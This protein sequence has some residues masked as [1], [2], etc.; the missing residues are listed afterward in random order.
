MQASIQSSDPGLLGRCELCCNGFEQKSA[1]GLRQSM[2]ASSKAFLPIDDRIE[3]A[4]QLVLRSRVF[5]DIWF[6]FESNDTRPA[7]LNTM[8]E[9][10]EFFRFAPHAHL[11]AFVVTI[12]ALFDKR[13]DTLSLLNLVTEMTSANLLSSLSQSEVGALVDEAK[14]LV[15][16]IRILR[17]NAF[18]HR[19][20]IMSYDDVFKMAALTPLQMRK[21][22]EIAL[23]ITNQL[24]RA[25]GRGEHF[26]NELVRGAAEAMMKTLKDCHSATVTG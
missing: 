24:A 26:F 23:K 25:R 10:N 20:A 2:I 16:K 4:A 7:L 1:S 8:E 9:Y 19:S 22:T 5:F 3:R 14:P 21:L 12:C 18:A 17:H 13:R 6:Y 11:V 15:S